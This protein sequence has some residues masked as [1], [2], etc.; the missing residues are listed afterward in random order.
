MSIFTSLKQTKVPRSTFNLSHDYKT[1]FDAGELIPIMNTE[2]LPG[3]TITL[4][5]EFMARMAPMV[6]PPM[7]NVDTFIHY[8]YVPYRLVWPSFD[9]FI[10]LINEPAG[11]PAMPYFP[12]VF[13]EIGT[14]A[15]Y[16][17]VP[18]NGVSV[19]N[20]NALHFAAYNLIWDQY[21]KDQNLQ[22]YAEVQTELQDG[23]NDPVQFSLRRRAWQHDLFTSALPWEQFGAAVRIPGNIGLNNSTSNGLFARPDGTGFPA[24][25]G[26]VTATSAGTDRADILFGGAGIKY[27]PNGTLSSNGTINDLRRAF[28]LQR[29][30]ELLARFG[31]RVNE[32]YQ[33]IWN[34]NPGDARVDR[35]EYLGG[36]RNPM[37]ISE[38]LNTT[39]TDDAPQ[40]NM[41]G[42]GISVGGKQAFKYHVKEFGV[43]FGIASILPRTAYQQG[44][45]K[46]FSRFSPFDY[47]FPQF[48]HIGEEPIYNRELYYAN[49]G[50]NNNIFGYT[51]RYAHYKYENSLVTGEMQTSLNQWHWSRIFQNR[52]QLNHQFIECHPD[53]RIFA[54]QSE[55]FDSFYCHIYNNVY[56]SRQ[57][58]Y[59]GNP[60]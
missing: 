59:H 33:G 2:V 30:V 16:M 47:A 49:D 14:L 27:D 12:S 37:V 10:R 32:F 58:P 7:H 53:K 41:A 28:S 39:G 45:P 29:V 52:P 44:L 25:S 3:D 57:L 26:N 42:H 8:F 55:E 43:I 5:A 15:N 48:A 38:V 1:S 34:V 4:N 54:V 18:F 50:E 40:G 17:G 31:R 35:P 11:R 24:G 51:P 13:P 9:E 19:S 23:A 21:Y 22:S 46:K 60:I 20:V 6:H 36:V 56:V